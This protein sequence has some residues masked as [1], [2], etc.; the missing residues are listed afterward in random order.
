MLSYSMFFYMLNP[1]ENSEFM[2]IIFY[3]WNVNTGESIILYI[4]KE[5]ILIIA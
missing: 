4:F 1:E 3:C 2:R 5:Y